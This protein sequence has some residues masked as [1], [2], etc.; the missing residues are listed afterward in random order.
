MSNYSTFAAQL[1][2]ALSAAFGDTVTISRG[3]TSASMTAV[4]YDAV[5]Q[6]QDVGG[7]VIEIE[8]RDIEVAKSDLVS[9]GL[10]PPKRG[11]TVTITGGAA[12]E[13]YPQ[14]GSNTYDYTDEREVRVKIH[15]VKK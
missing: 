1:D 12:Y 11:D 6:S 3:A 10:F 9:A 14:N 13:V 2:T 7:L 4:T 15:A 5:Y 8:G